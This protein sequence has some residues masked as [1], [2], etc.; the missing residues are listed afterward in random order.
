MAGAPEEIRTERLVLRRL[1]DADLP[2][3]IEVHGDAET[4]RH[5]PTG[6]PTLEEIR[7]NLAAWQRD[8]VEHGIGYWAIEDAGTG[9]VLGFGG[10]RQFD[11]D[12]RPELN[13]YYRFRPT[14]WGRGYATEMARAAVDWAHAARPEQTVVIRTATTN[15]AAVRVAE[16]LGFTL[17]GTRDL[18]GVPASVFT[19]RRS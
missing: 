7:E 19:S 6:P 2:A 12:G 11:F 1:V 4:N 13:L 10:L 9:E 18:E 17:L 14:A 8:W 16:R 15:A 5:N 3:M